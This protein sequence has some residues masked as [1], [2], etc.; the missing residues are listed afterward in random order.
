MT[1]SASFIADFTPT[2]ELIDVR[3]GRI[4]SRAH[5]LAEI[6]ARSECLRVFGMVHGD[7]IVIARA[8][9]LDY[10]L[11]LFSSWACGLC[12]V[13]VSPGLTPFERDNVR[14]ATGA[15]AWLD[16]G[17]TAESVQPG[18]PVL[19]NM[20]L[21][22]DEPAL[23]LMTSG[24]TGH[25]KGVVHTLRSLSMRVRLNI[26]E[27]SPDALARSLCVLPVHFGHGL[28]GNCLTPLAAG[29]RLYL[30]PSP[31]LAELR[32]LGALLDRERITFMS[33]VPAFWRL[34][35]RVSAR[36]ERAPARVHVG[37]APLSLDLWR[38]I[39]GWCG[40]EAVYNLFGMTEAAN[41]I[42]GASLA[43]AGERDGHVGRCWGGRLAVLADDGAIQASG[44]GEVL[45]R[46]PSLMAGYWNDSDGT[47]QALADGW[48]HTGDIG[49]LDD[50]GGLTLV[51]RIK[52]EINCGGI[53]VHA[54]EVDRMLERHPDVEEACAFGLPDAV[55]GECVAA[56]V[57]MRAGASFDERALK[58]WC[59]TQARTEAVPARLF[60]LSELPRNARGK[61]VRSEVKGMMEATA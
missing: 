24:T 58:N 37:S 51:G 6:A 47:A 40:T 43:E 5:L 7:R 19:A 17:S 41:W 12:A 2:S 48:L 42:A 3:S 55:A 52:S 60:A 1:H 57:V 18:E 36:P 32:G 29:G 44:T 27:I 30:W 39:A 22:P 21:G 14:A 59:R 56:A 25:P 8:E 16:E 45:V 28:I 20:P 50:C 35:L 34:A 9:G 33:S 11:D 23:I 61:L 38:A 54:E 49:R 46:T 13:A 10:L 4:L 26:A 15:R 31:D 53:K